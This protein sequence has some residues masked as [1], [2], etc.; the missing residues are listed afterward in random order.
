MRRILKKIF[1]DT[2][3]LLF[4]F[5]LLIGIGLTINHNAYYRSGFLGSSNYISGGVH[6]FF[7]DMGNYFSLASENEA[8]KEQN[9][10]LLE[11]LFR[12]KEGE[13][14]AGP[15]EIESLNLKP[16]GSA[17]L[18]SQKPYAFIPGRIIKNSYT[19]Y[20]NYLTLSLGKKDSIY[21]DMGVTNEKGIIGIVVKSGLKYAKIQSILNGNSRINAKIKGSDFFGAL[22]WNGKAPNLVQLIDIPNLAVLKK[23]DTIITGG[24]SSIFPADLPIG[25]IS[26]FK[27]TEAKNYFEI[28]VRLFNDMQ[29]L[30]PVYLIKNRDEQAIKAIETNLNE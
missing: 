18:L 6:S 26:N 4:L 1:S 12:L 20:N 30:G 5:Y 15:D 23:R 13:M 11:Q 7:N 14:V 16:T 22:V 17:A 28:E 25:T 27:L 10:L 29:N 19:A 2:V 9:S 3:R 21:E 24:M 8:L